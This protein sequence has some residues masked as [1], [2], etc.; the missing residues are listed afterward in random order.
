M[1]NTR[2]KALQIINDVLYKG[3]F[4]EESLEILKASNIDER[5]F[6]F[7]KE[8][9][10]GVVRN[11][12]YLD[13]V[14]RQNSRVRFNRIHRIILIILEMA[15]Y[16]MYFLDKVPDYSI[17]DESVNLAKIYGNKGSI[18]FTNGILRSIAKKKPAQVTLKNSIDNLSTYYSHPRFYTE[19][20]YENYG[21]EFTKKLLKANNEKAP[22]TI[23]VN[24]FKTNRDDLIKNLSQLGF[25]IEETTYDKA[26]NVLNPNG[27]IDT[28]YFE[29][30]HFYVQDL[31]SIL[32]SSF[33]NPRKDSKVLDLC[34][35][36][37]GKTTHL[38][39]LM[40][41]TGE[42]VACDK[43]KGKINLIKENAQRLGC[44]NISPMIND[45]RVLNDDFVNKFDYV[46][47]DAPC[48]GTGLYRKKPDI[49]WNKGIDDLKEL[50]KIQLEIL[51][52]AKEYVKDQGLLLYST[53]SLSKI[54][55]E[56]VIENFLSEN[57]NFKIKKL[58]DKEVLKLFPS[59]D[60]SDGFSICL[61]EKN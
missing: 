31:G 3:T 8:I 56:D 1:K 37:G 55:N 13:Y 36:P 54:E 7:I 44:K 29:K 39:E 5:D 34:A 45:A 18:S 20:F 16:Q 10:T 57:K 24:S 48:S 22:F 40:K 58:R 53:C 30:G 42:I 50:G 14:I 23:R 25:E 52:N 6:A 46:L 2:E 51:N 12:T 28:E 26:L 35:A 9:T 43:S 11:I 47:V 59:V 60:G 4:L 49:K 21:E 27:I 33:L 19:Y 32:V 41:N 61:L 15:I 17:V 38:S